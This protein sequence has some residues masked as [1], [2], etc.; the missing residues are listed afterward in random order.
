MA[1]D[2]TRGRTETSRTVGDKTKPQC[3]DS[4]VDLLA[5]ESGVNFVAG[6]GASFGA[7]QT[8]SKL[9]CSSWQTTTDG[10]GGDAKNKDFSSGKDENGETT[11]RIATRKLL[12]LEKYD[13]S[14]PLDTFLAKF[15]NCAGYNQWTVDEKAIL[16]RDS[17]TGSVSQIL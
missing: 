11:R 5:C 4:D 17:L 3:G 16:L 6:P 13:D 12:I 9:G 10:A 15:R 14:T 2:T 7:V 1:F 8:E